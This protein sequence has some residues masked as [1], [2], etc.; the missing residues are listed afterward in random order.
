MKKL[1]LIALALV[2][3][4]LFAQSPEKFNFQGAAKDASGNVLSNS[5]L[6][7]RISILHNGTNGT[8]VYS[9]SHNA[10]TNASGIFSIQIGGGSLL[11]GNFANIDWGNGLYFVKVEVDPT[12]GTNYNLLSNTQLLSVPY[13]LHAKT[14]GSIDWT[15]IT[16]VP[17]SLLDGDSDIL[18]GLSCGVNQ[19][20]VFNGTTWVCGSLSGGGSVTW[21]DITNLPANISAF[22]GLSCSA[23]QVAQYNG[24][25]WTCV[26]MTKPQVFEVNSS[27]SFNLTQFITTYTVIPGLT[28]TIT[29]TKP[30]KVYISSSGGFQCQAAGT[31][32]AAGD[33]A[34]HVNGSTAAGGQARVV[35]ANTSGL[36][37]IL[38][39][40]H[41][42]RTQSLPAGTHT[43]DLRIKDAN[44]TADGLIGGSNSL[45]A[46]T[47]TIIVIPD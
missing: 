9:E 6:G 21:G 43:I 28:Q 17:A 46:S 23:G 25:T 42:Q 38:T 1:L 36:G 31:A 45:L 13:A 32:Y 12:G 16:N 33:L 24:T 34:I 39:R 4:N 40:Y 30:S 18:A 26:D 2:Q 27:T 5:S 19:V 44:G 8:A 47:F 37:N 14:V 15:N 35:A 11:S 41:V 29:L 7:L 3:L 22:A 20:A 10:L